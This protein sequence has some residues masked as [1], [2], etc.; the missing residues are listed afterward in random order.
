MFWACSSNFIFYPT[1]IQSRFGTSVVLI[2]INLDG[3]D[4]LVIGSPAYYNSSPVDYNVSLF[5]SIRIMNLKITTNFS[6]V[7]FKITFCNFT[8]SKK[9][10]EGIAH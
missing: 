8:L 9:H 2:D 7:E 3:I 5:I 4:D 10:F 1:Q 6:M